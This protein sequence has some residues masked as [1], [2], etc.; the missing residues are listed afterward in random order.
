MKY[1]ENGTMVDGDPEKEK[2]SPY[3][4]NRTRAVEVTYGGNEGM[5]ESTTPGKIDAFNFSLPASGSL[6]DLNEQEKQAILN[7]D[8]GRRYLSGE[9]SLDEQYGRYAAQAIQGI[10]EDP[11]GALEVI[12][13]RIAAG[14]KNFM[15]LDGLSD[16]EKLAQAKRYMTDKKI[17]VWHGAIKFT[18]SDDPTPIFW[19]PTL[20]STNL[21]GGEFPRMMDG[22]GDRAVKNNQRAQLAAK[23]KEAGVDLSQ[24]TPEA[25]AFVDE[26]MKENGSQ[27]RGPIE[28]GDSGRYTGSDDQYVIDEGKRQ[29]QESEKSWAARAR[30]KARTAVPQ[31]DDMGRVINQ[32]MMNGGMIYKRRSME[33]G[34]EMPGRKPLGIEPSQSMIDSAASTKTVMSPFRVRYTG[35]DEQ[36]NKLYDMRYSPLGNA[37]RRRGKLKAGF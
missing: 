1:A 3:T 26:W 15:P 27:Q 17:G 5:R 24:D 9:G 35:Y 30:E 7:S 23:A 14:D 8:F 31:Y 34:G 29:Y 13:A 16:E 36:G 32:P 11:Q 19:S 21:V 37:L 25:R 20:E 12:N 22:L 18:T 4:E 33:N 28:E 6:D 10:N 2:K